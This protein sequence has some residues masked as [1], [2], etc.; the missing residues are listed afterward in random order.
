MSRPSSAKETRQQWWREVM[1]EEP[2]AFKYQPAGLSEHADRDCAIVV[3]TLAQ[4]EM[5]GSLYDEAYG[6][7]C[8]HATSRVVDWIEDPGIRRV[9]E[10]LAPVDWDYLNTWRWEQWRKQMAEKQEEQEP[11]PVK[12]LSPRTVED[13]IAR[14]RMMTGQP[15]L[16]KRGRPPKAT[17]NEALAKLHELLGMLPEPP[18]APEPPVLPARKL[19]G[20]QAMLEAI[21]AEIEAARDKSDAAIDEAVDRARERE[22]RKAEKAWDEMSR[23]EWSLRRSLRRG[24]VSI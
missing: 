8:P 5:E 12:P 13:K 24:K 23:R 4:D 3:S 22:Q 9:E 10:A 20:K 17:K 19:S 14:R 16:K 11:E 6:P 1:G 2:I 7:S 21:R 18:V 15:P